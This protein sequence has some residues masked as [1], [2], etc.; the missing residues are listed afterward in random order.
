MNKPTFA[1]MSKILA[2]RRPA[3]TFV[4]EDDLV[5]IQTSQFAVQWDIIYEILENK[6]FKLE[7]VIMHNAVGIVICVR[8]IGDN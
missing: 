6:D 1:S 5:R 8:Y 4:I 7:E 3:W 2:A